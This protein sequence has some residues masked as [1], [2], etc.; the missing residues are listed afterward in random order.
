[1]QEELVPYKR[2]DICSSIHQKR[3]MLFFFTHQHPKPLRKRTSKAK[4]IISAIYFDNN[5]FYYSL[6]ASKVDKYIKIYT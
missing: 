2:L 3:Y 5:Y 6:I 1:M 4:G